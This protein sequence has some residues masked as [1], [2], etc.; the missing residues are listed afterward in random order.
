MP[1]ETHSTKPIQ[2]PMSIPMEYSGRWIA[3]NRQRN[4]I[5]ADAEHL[6]ELLD[7][8]GPHNPREVVFYKVPRADRIWMGG[9]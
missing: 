2:R 3:L 5:L 7:Q 8:I 4:R 9:K 1:Q 6:K